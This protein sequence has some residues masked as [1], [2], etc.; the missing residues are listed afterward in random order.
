MGINRV[1]FACI[2]RC[3]DHV[4]FA[5]LD[6]SCTPFMAIGR[7]GNSIAPVV[8]QY[9]HLACFTSMQKSDVHH[10]SLNSVI[11]I[12]SYQIMPFSRFRK[13]QSQ[14]GQS[15]PLCLE[16]AL[17]EG[18]LHTFPSQV[19]LFLAEVAQFLSRKTFLDKVSFK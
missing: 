10:L 2:T 1:L 13:L 9:H 3:S 19:A 4:P 8:P 15:L 18:K 11:P 17:N 5:L 12:L 14:R 16:D 7:G 6:Q